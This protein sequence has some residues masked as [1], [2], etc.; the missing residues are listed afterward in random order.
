MTP[1]LPRRAVAPDARADTAVPLPPERG[2]F[3]TEHSGTTLRE[4]LGFSADH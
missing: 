1:A 2:V 3:R 4:H